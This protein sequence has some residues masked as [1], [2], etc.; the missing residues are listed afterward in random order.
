MLLSLHDLEP[1]L[2]AR[3]EY[4]IQL[5]NKELWEPTTG[6]NLLRRGV[7]LGP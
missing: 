4:S 5:A 7:Q 2:Q 6:L 3:P 1:S